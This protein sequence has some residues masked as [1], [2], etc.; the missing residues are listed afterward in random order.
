MSLRCWRASWGWCWA[1]SLPGA[2]CRFCA[3]LVALGGRPPPSPHGAAARCTRRT[4]SPPCQA[5][6]DSAG[7][8]DSESGQSQ[9]RLLQLCDALYF[10]P[11]PGSP[12][13]ND[14]GRAALA[15]LHRMADQQER[16]QTA[17]GGLGL[18]SPQQ[19][20]LQ[21]QELPR[22]AGSTD[23]LQAGM[24]GSLAGGLWHQQA[25]SL[26]QPGSGGGRHTNPAHTQAGSPGPVQQQGG[27]PSPLQPLQQEQEQEPIPPSQQ[28]PLPMSQADDNMP[29]AA[30]PAAAGEAGADGIAGA[31]AMDF[32]ASQQGEVGRSHG[33]EGGGLPGGGVPLL[34]GTQASQP[35]PLQQE[36][37]L[38]QQ[39]LQRELLDLRQR[40]QLRR[41][42][43]HKE[44][45]AAEQQRRQREEQAATQAAVTAQQ[46]V[47]EDVLAE[48][49]LAEDAQ[50]EA[51]LAA[52][53]EATFRCIWRLL[54]GW[55]SAGD[56]CICLGRQWVASCRS[57]GQRDLHIGGHAR[58]F[59]QPSHRFWCCRRIAAW[60]AQPAWTEEAARRASRSGRREAAPASAPNIPVCPQCRFVLVPAPE[61]AARQP[62]H[63]AGSAGRQRLG[64]SST[65]RRSCSDGSSPCRLGGLAAEQR[66]LHRRRGRPRA[67]PQAAAAGASAPAGRPAA[68]NPKVRHARG[69]AQWMALLAAAMLPSAWAPFMCWLPAQRQRAASQAQQACGR[70][71]C[72]ACALSASDCAKQG[73]K[74]QP[75]AHPARPPCAAG[76]CP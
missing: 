59:G 37:T 28:G 11:S 76:L 13:G 53:S 35:D 64:C 48:D 5:G 16:E 41:L 1:S 7:E 58:P 52:A 38:A 21:G 68:L 46:R 51:W 39:Q 18:P 67:G 73:L 49:T 6:S 66:G 24:P 63:G 50:R 69:C 44:R 70:A 55:R 14:P 15:R 71:A 25:L 9:R 20:Q 45:V 60:R 75:A 12:T 26:H 54:G 10:M 17:A 30:A 47:E 31:A 4:P 61:A 3:H 34:A 32:A 56:T 22:A 57:R 62:R 72:A 19:Q 8:S 40:R 33:A 74:R 43:Q 36:A 2:G 29:D 27:E 23:Q 42:Q 65:G